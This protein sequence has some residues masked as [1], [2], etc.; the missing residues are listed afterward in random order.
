ME[1]TSKINPQ[2]TDWSRVPVE[3]L[4]DGTERQMIVGERVMVCRL[5]FA[6]RVVTPPHDHPHEQITLV[7]RGRVL[8]TVG[9][10][11]RVAEA[12]D[13]LHFPPGTWHGATMLD[14]EVVLVDIFSPIREDF[15]RDGS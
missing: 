3:V 1:V 6:P 10:E 2:H 14:E 13:V 5:R 9:D 12:G 11:Q 15:L 4:G 7:E 8:F